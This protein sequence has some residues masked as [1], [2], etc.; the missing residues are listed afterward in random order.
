MA[1]DTAIPI[2]FPDYLIA[3]PNT[4]VDLPG[5]IND[6]GIPDFKT[7]SKLPDLGHAGVL[8]I[9][10][11]SGTTK[12]YEYGRYDAAAIGLVRYQT[13]PDVRIKGGTIDLASLKVT[14]KAIS[15]KA[16]QRGVIAG[17]WIV[18]PGKYPMMLAYCLKR[19][20]D[21]TNPKRTP[22]SLTSNSCCHFMKET[23]EAAGVSMPSMWDPRPVSY[24]G[25]IRSMYDDL[26]YTPKTDTL[27]IENL[28]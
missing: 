12:Y 17:A 28:T 23:V 25:E 15:T 6:I 13:M 24:I 8:F 27:K 21:N 20:K 10:G 22:Y 4:N 18:V 16:G 7:P 11:A 9:Q 5:F 14:L 19:Y 3:V 2:V 1:D 26:D